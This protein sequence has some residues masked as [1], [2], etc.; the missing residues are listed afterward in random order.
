MP[1]TGL[2]D[3]H[4]AERQIRELKEKQKTCR[5]HREVV[6]AALKR[7]RADGL[8][9]PNLQCGCGI[10]DISPA[11]CLELDLCVAARF[12]KP[13][14]GDPRFWNEYPDGYYT[15]IKFDL[16]A[17]APKRMICCGH[18]HLNPEAARQ[19]KRAIFCTSPAAEGLCEVNWQAGCCPCE[20][21]I[22]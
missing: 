10:A 20:D 21:E 5:S 18:M 16:A 14:R 7:M 15:P 11:D 3:G 22:L 2:V 19:G 6:I 1:L 13:E 12:I 9:N 8:C 4:G 17:E